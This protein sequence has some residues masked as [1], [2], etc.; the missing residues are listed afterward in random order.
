M[1]VDLADNRPRPLPVKMQPETAWRDVA[2][3]RRPR[4]AY[5]SGRRTSLLT[6]ARGESSRHFVPITRLTDSTYLSRRA[7]EAAR[8]GLAYLEVDASA[9]RARSRW[10]RAGP[11]RRWRLRAEYDGAFELRARCLRIHY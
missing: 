7:T 1:L 5:P 2:H 10:P 11:R 4:G 3:V 9:D 8:R 6:E